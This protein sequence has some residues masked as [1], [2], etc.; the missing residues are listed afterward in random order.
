M[1]K[2][3]DRVTLTLTGPAPLVL[4]GIDAARKIENMAN[5]AHQRIRGQMHDFINRAEN[6]RRDSAADILMDMLRHTGGNKR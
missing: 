2:N 5:S 6:R 4:D 3:G 1:T